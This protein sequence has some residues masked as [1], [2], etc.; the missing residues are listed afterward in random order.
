MY[1]KTRHSVPNGTSTR[2]GTGSGWLTGLISLVGHTHRQLGRVDLEFRPAQPGRGPNYRT[3]LGTAVPCG[4][5]GLPR[6]EAR[7]ATA[8]ARG[9]A[10]IRGANQPWRQHGLHGRCSDGLDWTQRTPP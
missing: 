4:S 8:V 2:G 9:R 3:N 6:G 10:R 7:R 1:Q 5:A